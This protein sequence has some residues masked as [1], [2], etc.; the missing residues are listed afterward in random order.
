MCASCRAARTLQPPPPRQRGLA[1]AWRAMAPAAGVPSTPGQQAV[2]PAAASRGT[3]GRRLRRS[4]GT[5]PAQ[6][7][8]SLL[9]T[10]PGGLHLVAAALPSHRLSPARDRRRRR[11]A[12]FFARRPSLMCRCCWPARRTWAPRTAPA[13]WSATCTAAATTASSC[14]TCRRRACRCACQGVLDAAVVM[15]RGAACC[16]PAAL[17]TWHEGFQAGLASFGWHRR[18]QQLEMHGS[19]SSSNGGRNGSSMRG[20]R[21]AAVGEQKQHGCGSTGSGWDGLSQH[22]LAAIAHMEDE[23]SSRRSDVL[24]VPGRRCLCRCCF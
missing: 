22:G 16:M 24:A 2:A 3:V 9:P 11:A 4:R 13:P 21:A 5:S 1:D 10:S 19:S 7:L 17:R 14:S 12:P 20:L 8:A 23:C 6:Q 18:W 15:W